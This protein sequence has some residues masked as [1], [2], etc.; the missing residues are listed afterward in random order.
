MISTISVMTLRY[1][2]VLFQCDVL[3]CYLV[4]VLWHYAITFDYC[5][6]LICHSP[7]AFGYYTLL[8][9]HCI[10]VFFNF[11]IGKRGLLLWFVIFIAQQ[12]CSSNGIHGP[13]NFFVQQIKGR[14]QSVADHL[15][16]SCNR[17]VK[18]AKKFASGLML[19]IGCPNPA[20]SRK[21]CTVYPE[22]GGGIVLI[23]EGLRPQ[24]SISN[25]PPAINLG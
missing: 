2:I 14:W 16:S 20:Q 9:C 4:L 1:A 12:Y 8:F 25:P 22:F 5:N 15:K 23:S 18:A 19:A 13:R 7:L 21:K 10:L 24:W 3:I 17:L 6:V 11:D